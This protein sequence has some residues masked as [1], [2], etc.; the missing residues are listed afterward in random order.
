MEL[1]HIAIDI[2][3]GEHPTVVIPRRPAFVVGVLELRD[4]ILPGNGSAI[5]EQIEP[6]PGTPEHEL[7]ILDGSP[8]LVVCLRH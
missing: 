7:F 3:V 2:L 6:V 8:G 4:A 1:V 5:G